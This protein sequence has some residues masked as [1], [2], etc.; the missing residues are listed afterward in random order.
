[1]NARIVLF[2]LCTACAIYTALV[3]RFSDASPEADL[4]SAEAALGKELWQE[5]NCQSCHQLYGLGGYMGPDLTN[6]AAKGPA[7]MRAFVEKG[8]GRMPDFHLSK[9]EVGRLIAFLQWVDK[10]G[11]NKVPDSA[12]HWSGSYSLNP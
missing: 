4:L 11:Q 3:Y 9:T 12:L 1:M 2:L 6:V 5:K 10:S 7:Y 8:T